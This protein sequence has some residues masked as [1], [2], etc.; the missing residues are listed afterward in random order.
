MK[1][2]IFLISLC[3]LSQNF[4]IAAENTEYSQNKTTSAP[5]P[6][7]GAFAQAI[8]AVCNS[9]TNGSSQIYKRNIATATNV[10]KSA[11]SHI[12]GAAP[13]PAIVQDPVSD[14]VLNNNT[15]VSAPIPHQTKTSAAK[16]S[17][18]TTAKK[19]TKKSK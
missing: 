10:E 4:T 7:T 18:K 9:K 16:K 2:L 1:K 13:I 12:S 6:L 8:D 5:L 3:L 14:N 15:T 19:T 11:A 17:T